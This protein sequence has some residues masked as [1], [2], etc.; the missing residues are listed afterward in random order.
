MPDLEEL[1]RHAREIFGD[2]LEAVDAG[3]AVLGAVEV[4]GTRLRVCDAEFDLRALNVYSVALGKAAAAMA[5]ALDERLGERLVRGVISSPPSNARL[6]RRWLAFDGGHPLPNESS[7]EAARA[8]FGL[9]READRPSALVIFLVSGGGSAMLEW[10]RDPRVTLEDLRAANR[11]LVSC[12]A[13]IEEVNSVRRALSAV[14]GGGLSSRAPRAAQFTLIISDVAAG[15][16]YDVASGPTLAP[17]AD[18]P[19]A[20]EVVERHGLASKLPASIIQ[21]LEAFGEKGLRTARAASPDD[22]P[23][24]VPAEAPAGGATSTPARRHKVLLDNARARAA[25]AESARA[26]GF[27]VETARDISEQPVGEGATALV[28]RLAELQ[29]REGGRGVCLISGGEF[30]CP[31]RG[32]GLGG[33]SSETALRCAFAFEKMFDGGRGEVT[34]RV[35]VA[36][37]AGTDGV[38]GNSPAAGALADH[39]TLRRARA[40]GLDAPKFLE[41]SDAY[42]FFE[43]LGDAIVTGPTGTNVRDVRILLAE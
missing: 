9:L 12:G 20:R 41:E 37:C 32:A 10:P 25:A 8:A 22:L 30:A 5:S 4:E 24:A 34:P 27:A 15:R 23:R 21:A 1:R 33:R 42:S 36:L 11:V 17:P 16:A 31:V 28:S 35:A 39:S 19:A 3:R 43:Q 7:I 13:G 29:R 38:D 40:L 14:K 18:A 6:S 26:R 2:V